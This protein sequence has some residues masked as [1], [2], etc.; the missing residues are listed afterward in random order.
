MVAL[1]ARTNQ[2]ARYAHEGKGPADQAARG[3]ARASVGRIPACASCRTARDRESLNLGYGEGL[4]QPAGVC[5]PRRSRLYIRTFLVAVG[6]SGVGGGR[7]DVIMDCVFD[8]AA[9]RSEGCSSR[10]RGDAVAGRKM[11]HLR[12][13]A[14]VPAVA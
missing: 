3:F 8:L 9:G 7:E 10:L 5:Q 11:R 4:L 2:P 1:A 14:G 13:L 12:G 6:R